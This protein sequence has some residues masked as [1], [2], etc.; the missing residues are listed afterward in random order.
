MIVCDVLLHHVVTLIAAYVEGMYGGGGAD[1]V[2]RQGIKSMRGSHSKA[3]RLNMAKQVRDKKKAELLHSRRMAAYMPPRVVAF[4]QLSDQ[5]D[6][7]GTWNGVLEAMQHSSEGV[8]GKI[9]NEDT[10]DSQMMED[11]PLKPTTMFASGQKRMKVTLVPPLQDRQDQLGLVEMAKAADVVVC[12]LPECISKSQEVIDDAGKEAITLL[13]CMGV[14]S[15]I[16]VTHTPEAGAN[17]LKERSA[18]KKKASEALSSLLPPD[19]F[20]IMS[21]DSEI[22]FKQIVR[23]LVDSSCVVPVWR[24]HRPQLVPQEAQFVPSSVGSSNGTLILTGYIRGKGMSVNQPIHI[25]S[26]GDF[27]ISKIEA[28]PEPVKD[29]RE[30]ASERNGTN[31]MMDS[32]EV[33]AVSTP[34]ERESLVRE[35]EVDPLDAEQTWPTEEE[36]AEAERNAKARKR[37]LPKGTSDYQAAWIVDDEY[38]SDV[39]EDEDDDSTEAVDIADEDGMNEERPWMHDD[40]GTDMDLAEVCCF[41]IRCIYLLSPR[42]LHVHILCDVV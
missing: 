39:S 27:H 20:K 4:L 1:V 18:A 8:K 7:A 15:M 42:V 41:L 37:R 35:N 29:P 22:D 9:E 40:T 30:A 34:E 11:Y 31:M 36:L 24:Q 3:D 10:M 25:P 2:Q 6:V 17:A 33:L 26:A 5:V 23:H 28:V 21:S 16:A 13:R 32:V 19:H 12:L 14:P 38:G